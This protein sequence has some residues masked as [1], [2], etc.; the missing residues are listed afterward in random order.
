MLNIIHYGTIIG[1]TFNDLFGN[2]YVIKQNNQR[3]DYYEIYVHDTTNSVE[4]S[5]VLNRE[6]PKAIGVNGYTFQLECVDNLP[7]GGTIRILS[8]DIIKNINLLKNEIRY[9]IEDLIK[10]TC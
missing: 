5:F 6:I 7:C 9:S 10:A 3:K 8:I 2:T 1:E 4:Y